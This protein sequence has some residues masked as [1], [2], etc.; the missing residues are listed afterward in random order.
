[1]EKGGEDNESEDIQ[2]TTEGHTPKNGWILHHDNAPAHLSFI[3]HEFLAQKGILTLLHPPYSPNIDTYDY[4]LFSRMKSHLK[5]TRYSGVQDV[6][7]A[8]TM[9]LNELTPVDYQ[10]CFQSWEKY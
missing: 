5:E 9:V 2:V 7:K 1:M 3:V 10:G 4:F 6:K 8:V